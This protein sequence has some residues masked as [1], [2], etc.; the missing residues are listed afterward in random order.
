[1]MDIRLAREEDLPQ[2]ISILSQLNP[3]AERCDLKKARQVFRELS[4]S[5]QQFIMVCEVDG[6][7]VGT[8]ELV[9]KHNLTH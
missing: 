8:A 4:R 9:I 3:R 2:L 1:M 7:L 6:R 5:N